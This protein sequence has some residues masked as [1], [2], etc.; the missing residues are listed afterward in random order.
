MPG[1]HLG[2]VLGRQ[3]LAQRAHLAVGADGDHVVLLAG[4]L[5]V[6]FEHAAAAGASQTLSGWPKR[7]RTSA[8]VETP[9]SSSLMRCGSQ[10]AN[11]APRPASLL[12]WQPFPPDP[13]TLPHA[14]PG[15]I[16]GCLRDPVY[17]HL[18]PPRL[19]VRDHPVHRGLKQKKPDLEAQQR[20]GRALLWDKHVD[21]EAWREYREAEVPQQPYVYQTAGQ[22][23]AD[24]ARGAGRRRRRNAT[25]PTTAVGRPGR[26]RRRRC[27]PPRCPT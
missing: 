8:S 23:S 5:A 21:R 24:P 11:A 25:L 14:V 18:P 12:P 16:A 3:H 1:P 20:A 7:A 19:P 26:A 13:S 17:V 2:E 15:K 6:V 10:P 27:W 9:S 22:V 4:G